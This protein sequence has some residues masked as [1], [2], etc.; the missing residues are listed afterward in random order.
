MRLAKGPPSETIMQNC[1]FPESRFTNHA[2]PKD[3]INPIVGVN[4]MLTGTGN[5]SS[6]FQASAFSGD[7]TVNASAQGT[8]PAIEASA[9]IDADTYW[10]WGL[11]DNDD[12]Y[13]ETHVAG[14]DPFSGL[15]YGDACWYG[16]YSAT[17]TSTLTISFD[18]YLAYNV[19]S[20]IHE[21]AYADAEATLT[22]G[23]QS[24]SDLLFIEALNEM[25]FDNETPWRTLTLG[26]DILAGE[27]VNFSALVSAQSEIQSAPV[28]AGIWLLGSGLAGLLGIRRKLKI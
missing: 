19:T 20:G 1:L 22:I 21:T 27:T 9:Q 26:Y 18:Y 3:C 24:I 8:T 14:S 23:D 28:P 15:A 7:P 12:L 4:V 25:A 16:Q 13:A 5:S 2:Q 6:G 11:V 10:G 17:T